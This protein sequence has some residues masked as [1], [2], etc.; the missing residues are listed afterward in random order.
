MVSSEMLGV[1]WPQERAL[2]MIKPPCEFRRSR[3]LE[4][5]HCIFVPVENVTIEGMRR[6]V[7]HPAIQEF[8]IGMNAFAV[9]PRKDGRRGGAVEAL[10]V[11]A[12]PN[13]QPCLLR[14]RSDELSR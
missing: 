3:I 5:H 1:F 14:G 10:V 4:I 7:G 2:M 9:E 8:S 6:F 11:E 13:L 12:D